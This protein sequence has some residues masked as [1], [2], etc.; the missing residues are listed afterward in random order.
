MSSIFQF[1]RGQETCVELEAEGVS[2]SFFLFGNPH[3]F[4]TTRS[5][6]LL[7]SAE[8]HVEAPCESSARDSLLDTG[9]A[10]RP[11]MDFSFFGDKSNSA[12]G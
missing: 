7:F 2:N 3:F 1:V 5:N 4:S 12:G 10:L 11:Y 9:G 8:F 6:S